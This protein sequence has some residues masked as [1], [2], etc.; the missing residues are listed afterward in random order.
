[1]NTVLAK[2]FEELK[3]VIIW[4][5]VIRRDVLSDVDGLYLGATTSSLREWST[6]RCRGSLTCTAR[7]GL[8]D[9][10]QV[11]ASPMVT[12]ISEDDELAVPF[13]LTFLLAQ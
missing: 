2:L 6:K 7:R 8:T 3:V 5:M 4:C 12:M 11:L 9:H 13:L 1:M 10:H